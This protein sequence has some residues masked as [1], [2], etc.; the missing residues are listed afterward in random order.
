MI[1]LWYLCSLG[2]PWVQC[3]LLWTYRNFAEE[4]ILQITEFIEFLGTL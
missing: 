1:S 2:G 4:R 3:T